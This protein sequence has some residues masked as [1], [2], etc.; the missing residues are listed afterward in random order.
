VKKINDS[1]EVE[2]NSKRHRIEVDLANLPR[3]PNLR[4]KMSGFHPSDRDQIRKA[5]IQKRACQLFNHD[6]PI[7]EFEKTMR[8]FNPAWF[9]KY[10]WFKDYHPIVSYI[11]MF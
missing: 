10:K 11:Y 7:K 3:D 9:K 4:K 1:I 2:S 5:F 6:F 8:R